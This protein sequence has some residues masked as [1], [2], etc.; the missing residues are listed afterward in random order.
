MTF[1]GDVHLVGNDIN[2]ITGNDQLGQSATI[3]LR[4]HKGESVFDADFGLNWDNIFV[5]KIIKDYVKNDIESALKAG[6]AAF[7]GLS[8]IV[9]QQDSVS[10]ALTVNVG[11]ALTSGD[12]LETEVGLDA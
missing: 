12:S 9:F 5:R 4:T 2:A 11:I 6:N 8:S 10:R 3:I 1:D 7:S